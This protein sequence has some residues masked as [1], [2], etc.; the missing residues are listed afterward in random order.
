MLTFNDL[1]ANPEL[2]F[3]DLTDEQY[4][5]YEYPDKEVKIMN[6]VALNVSKSGGHRVLDGKGV[7]HYLPAGWRHLYWVVKDDKLHFA[8]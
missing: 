7:S 6:P 8:F 5:V 3:G 4:R 1:K 2:E